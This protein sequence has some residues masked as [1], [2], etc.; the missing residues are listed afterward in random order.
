[1]DERI[2]KKIV[3]TG[4]PCAG[5]TTALARLSDYFERRGW[6]VITLPETATELILAG[7]SPAIFPDIESFEAAIIRE[8]VNHENDLINYVLAHMTDAD[9]IL[10]ILDRGILDTLAYM[11]KAQGEEVIGGIPMAA[12]LAASYDGVIHLVTAADGAEEFYTLENNAARQE[13]SLEDARAADQRTLEAWLGYDHLRIVPN[14]QNFEEKMRQVI[15]EVA[16]L[17]GEPEPCEIE[18]KYLI[19]SGAVQLRE[20]LEGMKWVRRVEILQIYLDA[21]EKSETR[22][23]RRNEN[24]R[25]TFTKTTKVGTDDP[26]KRIE[27]EEKISEASFRKAV[28]S[29]GGKSLPIVQKTRFLVPSRENAGYIEID[30]FENPPH[31]QRVVNS[32]LGAAGGFSDNGTVYDRV[33]LEHYSEMFRDADSSYRNSDKCLVEIELSALTQEVFWPSW[34]PDGVEVTGDS[35]YSNREIAKNGGV[36]PM[37]SL[38]IK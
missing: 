23:R 7:I 28:L 15:R 24:G 25:V 17:I 18:R 33:I 8:Q 37:V 32:L 1:M 21:D 10:I 16:H 34:L 12:E 11:G 4:G 5:K 35:R 13:S 36:L 19:P 2:V 26:R 29:A 14:G 3:L 20:L 31:L 22:V 6:R 38:E 9:K 30:F 27:I